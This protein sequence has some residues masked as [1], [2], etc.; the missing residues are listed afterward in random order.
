V[1]GL[2]LVPAGMGILG[3]NWPNEFGRYGIA[4]L[5]GW[6]SGGRGGDWRGF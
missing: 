5:R 1:A 4:R 6:D 2:E 3:W